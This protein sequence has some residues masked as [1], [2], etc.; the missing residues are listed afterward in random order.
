MALALRK[1]VVP[2]DPERMVMSR[3]WM[4]KISLLVILFLL[5]ACDMR[6]NP[7]ALTTRAVN[8]GLGSKPVTFDDL[9]YDPKL[10]RVIVPAAE[11]GA[12]ALVDP[13]SGAA[14]V[15]TG[16]AQPASPGV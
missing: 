7:Y 1:L 9:S 12:L 3:S 14:Q 16:F 11:S 13:L 6:L 15:I 5:T 4:L 2:L 8:L 10:A